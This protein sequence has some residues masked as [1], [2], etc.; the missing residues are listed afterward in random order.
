MN[1]GNCSA[2]EEGVGT[3]P[4][5]TLAIPYFS[6]SI[7]PTRRLTIHACSYGVMLACSV[8]AQAEASLWDGS[9]AA[10]GGCY[11]VGEQSRDIDSKI[12]PTP[13]GG[14]SV[15]QICERVGEGPTLQKINGKFNYTVYPGAQCGNGPFADTTI[16]Q[17][18][19]CIGHRGVIG[20]DCQSRGP[21][22]DLTYAYSKKAK[23][24][25]DSF[26]NSIVTGGSR[27]IEP[28]TRNSS[29]ADGLDRSASNTSVAEISRI[30][31]NV[32]KVP[33]R[34]PKLVVPETREQIR[35]RQLVHL[36][37]ARQ[38]ANLTA[39]PLPSGSYVQTEAATTASVENVAD[40]AATTASVES[41]AETAATTPVVTQDAP[42]TVAALKLPAEFSFG[43]PEFNYI[44]AAPVTYDFGGAGMSITASKSSHNRM[45]Y[46]VTAA[47]AE[48]YKEAALGVGMFINP[49]ETDRS[50][51]IVRA[52]VEYG[53]LDFQNGAIKAS[54]SDSGVFADIT[55]KV[56]VTRKFKLQAGVSYSSFFEGDVIGIGAA[57]YQLTPKLDL[58]AKTE[59]GDNDLIG[60]GIRY[61]Y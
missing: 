4:V 3:N 15:T 43:D 25:A 24:T 38:R 55:T 52:G 53:S 40:T 45:Q 7:M 35:A 36:E 14:Q 29:E 20:E 34:K 51:L 56:A 61:H 18:R 57:F 27:Y 11:C 54:H 41:V 28:P 16:T 23:K 30:R 8:V 60:F 26:E 42:P 48:T 49:D 59:I 9:Y 39:K 32:K 50:M 47:A 6:E 5:A 17:A 33:Q 44:E 21:K 46:I 31:S 1:V 19:E 58:T 22:W 37:A 10:K 12:L 13:I 2:I